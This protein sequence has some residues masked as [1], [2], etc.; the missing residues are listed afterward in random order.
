MKFD[1][2]VILLKWCMQP[3]HWR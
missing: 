3:V 1:C 2:T